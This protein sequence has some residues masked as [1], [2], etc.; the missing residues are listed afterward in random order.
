LDG[1]AAV[2]PFLVRETKARRRRAVLGSPLSLLGRNENPAMGNFILI[3]FT[4]LALAAAVG[5][6]RAREN[7]FGEPMPSI[8]VY[9]ANFIVARG[10]LGIPTRILGWLNLLPRQDR[11]GPAVKP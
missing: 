1:V 2:V 11:S 10:G 7:E 9:A 4:V 5:W 8:A 3:L 6:Y